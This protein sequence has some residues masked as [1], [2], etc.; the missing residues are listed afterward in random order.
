M[1]RT[2]DHPLTKA[3]VTALMVSLGHELLR[4]GCGQQCARCEC[5]LAITAAALWTRFMREEI[6]MLYT[7]LT[8][9]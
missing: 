1:N 8:G 6:Q 2:Y 4:C 7:D 5:L 9:G 3:D